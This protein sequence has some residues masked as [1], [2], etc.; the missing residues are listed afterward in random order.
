MS[1]PFS[2]LALHG[3]DTRRLLEVEVLD[4]PERLPEDLLGIVADVIVAATEAITM[5]HTH[6]ILFYQGDWQKIQTRAVG[7]AARNTASLGMLAL[8]SPAAS[9]RAQSNR[10]QKRCPAAPEVQVPEAGEARKGAGE[11]HRA[12]VVG[13]PGGIVPSPREVHGHLGLSVT[14]GPSAQV[15]ASGWQQPL[16]VGGTRGE[17]EPHMLTRDPAFEAPEGLA[18]WAL[19][20][21][22]WT[23]STAGCIRPGPGRRRVRCD[24]G[25]DG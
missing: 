15:I 23:I 18:A 19:G 10:Q 21:L 16:S 1:G 3:G 5:I 13:V 22:P 11:A 14:S 17:A 9:S 4:V 24:Y 2:A 25:C 20:G 7:R 12:V 8:I 6:D